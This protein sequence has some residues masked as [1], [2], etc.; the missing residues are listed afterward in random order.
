MLEDLE[1]VEVRRKGRG[2]FHLYRLVRSDTEVDIMQ[3]VTT[4]EELNKKVANLQSDKGI[5]PSGMKSGTKV[6]HSYNQ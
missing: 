5:P 3:G 6:E 4:P 1:Y 2:G